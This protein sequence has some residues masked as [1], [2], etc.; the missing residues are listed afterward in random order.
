M[1]FHPGAQQLEQVGQQMNVSP[2]CV[3]FF[4]HFSSQNSGQLRNSIL[5]TSIKLIIIVK[6]EITDADQGSDLQFSKILIDYLLVLSLL[7]LIST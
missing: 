1:H 4:Y 2:V 7:R 3:E 5:E 6:G